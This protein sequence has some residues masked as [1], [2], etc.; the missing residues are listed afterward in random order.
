MP[1][2]LT[3][4]DFQSVFPFSFLDFSLSYVV[5]SAKFGS[6]SFVMFIDPSFLLR[7]HHLVINKN[8]YQLKFY[9]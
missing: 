2:Y 4:S 5:I 1:A 6:D 9:F 7:I 8:N 3:K